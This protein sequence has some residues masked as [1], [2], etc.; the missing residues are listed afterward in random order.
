MLLRNIGRG[1]GDIGL[2][3]SGRVFREPLGGPRV[4]PILRVD[5]GPTVAELA[6]LEAALPD[7]PLHIAAVLTGERDLGGW[8]G[9]G[10][11]AGWQD[12]IEAAREVLRESRVPFEIRADQA[13]PWHPG[14]CAALFVQAE[15]GHGVAAG[16]ARGRAAPAGHRGVRRTPADQRRWSWTCR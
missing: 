13:A 11:L 5:R 16:R 14:R 1:F 4:A 15:E 9:A 2:F 12:A 8:W 7:Q 3:E 6:V 10:R